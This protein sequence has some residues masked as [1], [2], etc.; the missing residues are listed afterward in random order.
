VS[1]LV[2]I[3]VMLLAA[4]VVAR[5]TLELPEATPA[6]RRTAARVLAP[7]ST[8]TLVA[9]AA[10]AVAQMLD[11]GISGLGL[12][13]LLMLGA[14]VLLLRVAVPEADATVAPEPAAP[15]PRAPAPPAPEPAAPAPR[16]PAPPAPRSPLRP[17]DG[18]LWAGRRGD[19]ADRRGL[20]QG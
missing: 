18:A 14:G 11:G 10:C 1:A 4:T 12:A 6:W 5:L 20:W 9:L 17:T 15:A 13:L 19:T 3:T 7:L 16:A 2:P 8:W